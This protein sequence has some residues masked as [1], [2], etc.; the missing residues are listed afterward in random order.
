M[1]DINL[2]CLRINC[3]TCEI[4]L[5][6]ENA[7]IKLIPSDTSLPIMTWDR[8]LPKNLLAVYKIADNIL[9]SFEKVEN[10]PL[11]VP[12]EYHNSDLEIIPGDDRVKLERR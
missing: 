6:V 7:L 1:S 4:Q 11:K 8:R 5:D 3:K 9:T 10:A 12:L 2:L